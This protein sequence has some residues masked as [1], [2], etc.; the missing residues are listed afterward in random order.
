MKAI[1]TRLMPDQQREKVAAAKSRGMVLFIAGRFQVDYT[2]NLG[3]MH[4]ITICQNSHF[5]NDDLANLCRLVRRGMVCIGPLIQDVVPP[6]EA[7]R[8]YDTLRDT[9]NKLF[10][11]VFDWK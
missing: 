9:P 4:E 10:G 2:F 7:K 6:T 5:D 1:V 11:T 3:Q 8:I